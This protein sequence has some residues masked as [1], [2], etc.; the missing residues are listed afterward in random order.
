MAIVQIS[1]A[2]QGINLDLPTEELKAGVWS[3]A[4]NMRF[5]NGY[6]QRFD[7]I[8]RIFDATS[9]TPYYLTYYQKPGGRYWVHAGTGKVFSDDGTTRTEITRIGTAA[10]TSLTHVTTTATLTTTAPHGMSTSDTIEVY[11]ASPNAYNGTFT[12]TVTGPSVFT[13]TMTS[14]PGANATNVGHLL[15]DGAVALDFTGAR[16]DRWSGGVLGGV[17][18]LNNGVDAPQYW[19]GTNALRTLPAWNATHTAQ[20][21]VPFKS[22]LVALDITKGSTRY[23]NMVKWSS[24]A[25]PGSL[26]VSWDETD[27]TIDA[28]EVDVAET[29]DYLVDALQLGDTLI[30]YKQRSAYVMRLIGQ[31]YIFQVQKLPGDAGMLARGCAVATPLGHVVLTAG[32]VVLN[33]GSGMQSIADGQV[34]RAIFSNFS[35]E[36]YQR[37]FVT[38]NPQKN[39]VLVCYPSADATDCDIAMVWN[40]KTQTWGQRDITGTH[41]GATGQI[42]EAAISSWDSDDESWDLDTSSWSEDPY[43]PNESRLL[44][45][46]TA[47]I[48]AF[49]VSSSDDGVNAL[50]GTLERTGMWIDDSDVNKLLRS[51][52]PR[53]DATK[54]AVVTVQAGANDLPS[55]AMRW[56]DA[57]SFTVGQDLRA[58]TFAQGKYLGLRISCSAPWRMR[59]TGMDIIKTGAF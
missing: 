38:S 33:N 43:S 35:T 53:I 26:P 19:T 58:Y 16:D 18:V 42:D 48:G 52:I 54:G 6:A 10:I 25:V 30:L 15:L 9:I 34:R 40:W 7:G 2:G 23:P 49:D 14:D 27:V 37:A 56:S 36:H 39:E 20:V 41:F 12:I 51:V 5:V 47:R 32:D 17:L 24:A 44:L 45:A 1:D 29:P 31:P 28:G 59:S 21:L 11:G 55:E 8:S 57:V 4:S 3:S 50:T 13:Y 22:Y 46:Q